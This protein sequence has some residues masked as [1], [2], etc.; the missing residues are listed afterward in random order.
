MQL[1]TVDIGSSLNALLWKVC[2]ITSILY[3]SLFGYVRIVSW[4]SSTKLH[5]IF[6]L[7]EAC[8]RGVSLYV[9]SLAEVCGAYFVHIG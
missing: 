6:F 1:P 2:L 8:M 4:G 3:S 9:S 7:I 5:C